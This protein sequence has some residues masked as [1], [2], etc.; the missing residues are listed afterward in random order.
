M[1]AKF[2]AK[3]P[4][5]SPPRNG[6]AATSNAR[7][8]RMSKSL[9]CSRNCWFR[10]T[11]ATIWVRLCAADAN[12]CHR[13]RP[14]KTID[15]TMSNTHSNGTRARCLNFFFFSSSRFEF[16]PTDASKATTHALTQNFNFKYSSSLIWSTQ[17]ISIS[18][19]CSEWETIE[20]RCVNKIENARFALLLVFFWNQTKNN[21]NNKRIYFL[22]L[23]SIRSPENKLFFVSIYQLRQST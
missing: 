2:N 17:P 22:N 18:N 6:S 19:E 14:P 4:K 20:F 1:N 5:R 3:W 7:P 11:Y 21:N 15:I 9:R 12:R 8:K 13:T 16:K 23:W 10:Q